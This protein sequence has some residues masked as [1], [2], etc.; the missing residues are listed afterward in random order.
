MVTIPGYS[1]KKY[2]KHKSFYLL[3]QSTPPPLHTHIPEAFTMILN[4][5]TFHHKLIAAA[6]Q[7]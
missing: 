7:Y 2:G 1:Q 4:I 5:P 6:G 3:W